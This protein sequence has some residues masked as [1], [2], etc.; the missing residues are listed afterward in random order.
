VSTDVTL[1]GVLKLACHLARMHSSIMHPHHAGKPLVAKE[2]PFFWESMLDLCA[3]VRQRRGAVSLSDSS[4]CTQ[5]CT[6]RAG[7]LQGP[8]ER[9]ERRAYPCA[10]AGVQ[11]AGL[12]GKFNCLMHC[13]A[14]T[15]KRAPALSLPRVRGFAIVR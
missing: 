14:P 13:R 5:S 3:C 10:D 9:R 6:G 4:A 7:Q 2:I 12:C 11:A 15:P 8:D 1:N